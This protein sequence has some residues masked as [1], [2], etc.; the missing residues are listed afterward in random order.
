MWSVILPNIWYSNKSLSNIVSSLIL[1]MAFAKAF[2]NRSNFEIVF[3]WIFNLIFNSA[4]AC[5]RFSSNSIFCG[6]LDP[7]FFLDVLLLELQFHFCLWFC[8]LLDLWFSLCLKSHPQ[9]KTRNK[10]NIIWSVVNLNILAKKTWEV[11]HFLLHFPCS[12]GDY[13]VLLHGQRHCGS[14]NTPHHIEMNSDSYNWQ[15]CCKTLY[16]LS[17]VNHPYHGNHSRFNPLAPYCTCVKIWQ[18]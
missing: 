2:C 3:A 12:L 7:K 5:I 9:C 17:Q 14:S 18:K 1:P 4:V 8:L 15:C 6:L 13:M 11:H 16:I 10:E